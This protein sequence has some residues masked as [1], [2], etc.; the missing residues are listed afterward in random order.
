MLRDY[1]TKQL[2]QDLDASLIHNPQQTIEN[3]RMGCCR[4]SH[5][6][7]TVIAAEL[8]ASF[9]IDL[10]DRNHTTKEGTTICSTRIPSSSFLE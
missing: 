7:L 5:I 4:S 3:G 1:E 8:S 6:L 9:R 2:T 10:I